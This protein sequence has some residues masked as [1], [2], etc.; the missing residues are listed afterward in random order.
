MVMSDAGGGISVTNRNLELSD[1]AGTSLPASTVLASGTFKPTDFEPG[2]VMPFPAPTGS[3]SPQLSAFNGTDPNGDWSLYVADDSSGDAGTIAGGWALAFT[4]IE[5]ISP[6]A[7]VGIV[8]ALG[9]PSDILTGETVTY[10][11]EVTNRGPAAATSVT[12]T[13][14][15]PAG[16]SLDS[17]SMSQ[18]GYGSIPGQ[19][20]FN[21]G[22]LAAGAGAQVM[23]VA[24]ATIA[25]NSFNSISITA[26]ETDLD[27]SD[28][29]ASVTT[30]VSSGV[31]A[32]LAG[33]YDDPN[34]V[35]EINLTGQPDAT[36]ILQRSADLQTWDPISTNTA[37]VSGIIKFTDSAS[38]AITQRFYRAL[39][40]TVPEPN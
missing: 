24:R 19:V 26:A 35:F 16:A 21:L 14:N 3:R 13:D 2:D 7:N 33:V 17:A 27:L 18:G 20:T 34:Q 5:P 38:T 6:L 30:L 40:V 28:N 36:Y 1:S 23:V 37:P 9:T 22:S 32:T 15:L 39:R 10:V 4:T 11:I 8:S 29:S 25:G 31:A 12:V